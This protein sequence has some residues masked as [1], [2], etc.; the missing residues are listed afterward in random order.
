[1]QEAVDRLLALPPVH[2]LL[3]V[4]KP[5]LDAAYATYAR[6]HDSVVASPRYKQ[7]YNLALQVR[8]PPRC[9]PVFH[10]SGAAPPGN[11]SLQQLLDLVAM[12]QPC[13]SAPL[14]RD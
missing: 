3:E 2:K 1:M 13:L 9:W 4:A 14:F 11:C 12:R 10:C 5:Q 6:L 8:S 7:T